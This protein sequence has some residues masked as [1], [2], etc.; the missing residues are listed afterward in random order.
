MQKSFSSTSRD[1]FVLPACPYSTRV[2]LFEDKK[3]NFPQKKN[4]NLEIK[5][6]KENIL[7]KYIKTKRKREN[8]MCKYWKCFMLAFQNYWKSN[9]NFV[10]NFVNFNS[11]KQ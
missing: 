9:G 4:I 1:Y 6:L 3:G 10:W 7:K 11:F 5:V 8:F 2:W